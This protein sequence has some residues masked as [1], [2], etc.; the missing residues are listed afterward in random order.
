[1][2]A[3]PLKAMAPKQASSRP[4][5]VDAFAVGGAAVDVVAGTRPRSEA[6]GQAVAAR[7]AGGLVALHRRVAHAPDELAG[8]EV[9]VGVLDHLDLVA[10]VDQAL[11]RPRVHRR[12]G[13]DR[14]AGVEAPARRVAGGLRRLVVVE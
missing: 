10:E 6:G 12:L 5:A 3:L 11:H 9:L 1:M 7:I 2:M 4:A 13:V 14:P 8:A